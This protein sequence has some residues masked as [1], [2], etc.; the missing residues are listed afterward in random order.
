MNLLQ[1][2]ALKAGTKVGVVPSGQAG[3]VKAAEVG[4]NAVVFACAGDSVDLSLSGVDTQ[5][6]SQAVNPP[7]LPT[8]A[9]SG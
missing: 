3:A 1:G 6:S 2:G 5:V 7:A 8:A 9:H 4:G